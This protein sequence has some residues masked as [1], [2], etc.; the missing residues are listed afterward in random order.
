MNIL[1]LTCV[2]IKIGRTGRAGKKGTAIS[3]VTPN[4]E[5]QYNL[6]EKR[7]LKGSMVVNREVLQGFEPNEANW[8]VQS[9]AATIQVD[10]VQHSNAGLVH[11]RMFGGIKGRRKSKKDRL[12]E[13]AARDA[14]KE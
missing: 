5:A 14:A 2:I 1:S 4:N 9:K 11:D 3:F 10:G 6:I 7:H 8:A 13:Q 12:R